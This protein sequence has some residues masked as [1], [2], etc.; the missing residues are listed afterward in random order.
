[1]LFV[2]VASFTCRGGR[3]LQANTKI[4][5]GS[6]GL[7]AQAANRAF[8]AGNL[9]MDAQSRVDLLCTAALCGL[10]LE[11]LSTREVVKRTEDTVA[12]EGVRGVSFAADLRGPQLTAAS[13]AATTV[14]DSIPSVRSVLAWRGDKTLFRYGTL[15]P[16]PID[17][18]ALGV[19]R[20]ETYYPDLQALPARVDFQCL[21]RN[22]P[23]ALIVPVGDTRLLVACDT[24]R[25][26][27]PKDTAWIRAIAA[28]LDLAFAA[29]VVS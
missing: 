2:L 9:A 13:W 8:L 10:I 5:L 15:G 26:L 23:S 1:M 16:K 18:T 24:K 6:A 29:D 14:A 12:L 22:T 21:P 25:A 19:V 7:V 17:T 27:S 4:A 20:G 28:R 11:G 3:A